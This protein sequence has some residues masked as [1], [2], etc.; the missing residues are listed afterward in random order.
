M[1]EL[2]L[3]RFNPK[4]IEQKRIDPKQGPPTILLIGSK[5]TGKTL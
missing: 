5:R 3:K 4:V 1:E 2:K